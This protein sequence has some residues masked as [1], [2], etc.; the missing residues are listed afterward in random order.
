MF[1]KA[2]QLHAEGIVSKLASSTYDSGRGGS[3]LKIKCSREQEFVI[4]G[5]TP[6]SK[7]G[8]GIG[9]LLL[10]YYK[11]GKLVYAGRSGTGFTQTMQRNLRDR[12]DRLLE[13]NPPFATLP[14]DARK[15]AR[16]VK[17]KL[18]AQVAFATW[19][20]DNLVRQAA[21]K[22][23]RED[24][25]AKE[26]VREGAQIQAHASHRPQ[27]KVAAKV[28]SKARAAPKA[29]AASSALAGFYLTHPEKQLDE[30]SGLTKQ[31]L[32][33]YYFAVADRL[34]PQIA[35]RPL[36]I[37]RCPEGSGKP[38]FFQK[39]IGSGLPDGIDTVP[40]RDRKTGTMEKYITVSSVKGLVG[41]AQM[42]VLEI[43]PWGSHN[44]SL[45]K[46]DRI[47]FD[48]DPDPSIPWKTLAESARGVRELLRKVGLKSFVKLTGGKGLHVVVPIR[49]DHAW[50]AV[51]GF[52]HG[53]ALQMEQADPDLFLTKMTKSA[54]AGKIYV[55]YLR[56]DR[57]STSVA[58]YSPR[59]RV[60]IPVSVPL[61]W[62]ELDG[63][64][65]PA[66]TV[67]DFASWKTRLRSDPWNQMS[68]LDQS[69]TD[70]AINAV[71][72]KGRSLG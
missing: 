29:A 5:F 57:G 49:A 3:W 24:K 45:E 46:P 39:H 43:H 72:A 23:L 28:I 38:C 17:P 12:L 14:M 35:D 64:T 48:L 18:V 1:S 63:R 69:L 33:E 37:V 36:S 2:C 10:G 47:V 32:A 19:T 26:V 54:R 55:D 67:A 50:P 7:G 62:K 61:N 27:R 68:E 21:F 13:K 25:A 65:A 15:N 44:R 31:E 11:D 70:A 53:V 59:A 40:V 42:G 34:L 71:A 6:P 60:G 30:A 51:K 41:L 9:A 52:A 16:W 66:F 58:P 20:A 56:N 22:G 4:G 8:H